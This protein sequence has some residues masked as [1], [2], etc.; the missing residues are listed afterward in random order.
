MQT[1]HQLM[2]LFL[3]LEYLFWATKQSKDKRFYN[4]AISHADNTMKNH[5]RSDYSSFHVVCYEPGPT[6]LRKQTHQGAADS[7]AWARGQAWALYG[8]TMMY[9]ETKDKKYLAQAEG[10]AKFI[11]N[12]PNLPKD[13]VPYWDF[14]APNIPNEERDASAGALFA[15][16]LFELST[17]SPKNKKAYFDFAEQVLVSLSSDAYMA[18]VGENNNFILMHS[19]GNKPSKSE[20]NTPIVYADYYYLEALLRYQKLINASVKK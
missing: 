16:S 11:M 2:H 12:H 10:I 15:S 8:Y 19:V 5:F 7:S 13:K 17:Y 9:R 1:K 14:N 6:V 4:I 3:H 18:K 20:I